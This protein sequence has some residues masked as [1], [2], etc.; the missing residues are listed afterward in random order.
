M[1]ESAEAMQLR[2]VREDR[3]LATLAKTRSEGLITALRWVVWWHLADLGAPEAAG[4][5]EVR[6]NVDFDAWGMS[7]RVLTTVVAA[8]QAGALTIEQMQDVLRRGEVL[9]IAATGEGEAG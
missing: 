1:A 2:M 5:V 8:W 7:G 4:E 9:P 3:I 6:L